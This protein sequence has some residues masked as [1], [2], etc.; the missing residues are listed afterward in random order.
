VNLSKTV[1]AQMKLS[2]WNP[3]IMLI[4]KYKTI[5]NDISIFLLNYHRITT[6]TFLR[7]CPPF[8]LKQICPR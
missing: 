4:Q 1:Y 3:S 6:H 8:P 5:E 2:T 7:K